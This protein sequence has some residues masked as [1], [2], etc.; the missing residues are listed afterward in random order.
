MFNYQSSN[1]QGLSESASPNQIRKVKT[2]LENLDITSM[3]EKLVSLNKNSKMIL[4]K[5]DN[6]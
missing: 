3:E 4:C 6:P 1:N 2:F 5:V